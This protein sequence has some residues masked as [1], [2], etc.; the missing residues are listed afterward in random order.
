MTPVSTSAQTPPPPAG[1]ISL[2]TYLET[3][4]ARVKEAIAALGACREATRKE[5]GAI[6]VDVYQ[7]ISRPNRFL[8]DEL[9][10]DFA[11][12]DAHVK[13]SKLADGLKAGLLAPPDIRPQTDWSVA[14]A[15]KAPGANDLY[16][17]THLDVHPP[18]LAD[19]EALLRPY[20]EKSRGDKGAERF[21]ALQGLPTPAEQL[22]G[23]RSPVKHRKNHMTLVEAWASEADFRAHEA[24]AHALEF[25]TKVAPLVG[26]QFD[27][28]LYQLVK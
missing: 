14:D 27:Q 10:K 1:R 20:V 11:A 5:A 25:R 23:D 28:R 26:A 12:Y 7:E 21:E 6:R 15:R 13:A 18:Y 24:S 2:V 9:W 16:V 22:L 19:L 17:F 4:P 8:I 3:D